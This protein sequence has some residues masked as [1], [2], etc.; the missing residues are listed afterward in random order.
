MA[1][2]PQQPVTAYLTVNGGLKAIDLYKRAFGAKLLTHK[3]AG[4]G[5]RV[6]HAALG[7]SG[8][9]V[10]LSDEFSEYDTQMKSPTT[11]G[12][13]SVHLHLDFDK[14]AKVD[15]AIRKAERAGCKVVLPAADAF[16]GMRYG[17]VQDPFGHAWAF[18]AALLVRPKTKR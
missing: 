16:W 15:A 10:M 5:K 8:V 13:T 17:R 14:P 7:I 3:M 9:M 6:L 11:L 4:D 12:G 18:G 1:Q 2:V